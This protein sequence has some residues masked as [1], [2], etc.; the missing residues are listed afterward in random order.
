ME[1]TAIV[2]HFRS[3]EEKVPRED[4]SVFGRTPPGGHRHFF[5]WPSQ[6]KNGGEI[7]FKKQS[8]HSGAGV[9]F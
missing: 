1:Y 2:I 5:K 8:A 6:A 4:N 3:G 9:R 7:F